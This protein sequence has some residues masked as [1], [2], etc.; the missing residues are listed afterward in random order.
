MIKNNAKVAAQIA[1]AL[2]AS[3]NLQSDS[4]GGTELNVVKDHKSCDGAGQGV[5]V[6]IGGSIM[7]I[8]YR[9]LEGNLEVSFKSFGLDFCT[10]RNFKRTDLKSF[11]NW[12]EA[13]GERSR[14]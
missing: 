5:P 1:V 12:L 9:V 6:V 4:T 10:R 14:D 11:R 2:E 3:G 7:D 13:W 8:H